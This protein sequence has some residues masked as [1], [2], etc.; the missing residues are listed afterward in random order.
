ML[1][2]LLQLA[3]IESVVLEARTRAYVE[4]RVRAGVLEQGSVDLLCTAGVGERMRREGLLHNGI[5]IGFAGKRHRIDMEA[6]TGNAITVYAQHEVVK[7]LIQA[8]LTAGGETLFEAA[9]SAFMASMEACPLSVSTGTE[10][11]R[12]CIA[13][14][15]LG[16]MD[17]MASA[18][19][20]FQRAR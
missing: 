1:A 8:R 10:W 14:S 13:I 15:S 19:G 12:N 6:L 11:L 18:D 17:F 2:H 20:R 16:A 3:G 7:D 5:E 4:S 9:K